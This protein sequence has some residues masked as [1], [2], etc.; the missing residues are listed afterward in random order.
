MRNWLARFLF[1]TSI[2]IASKE[3]LAMIVFDELVKLDA[4]VAAINARLDALPGAVDTSTFATVDAL[5]A[6]ANDVATIKSE[7]GT[8]PTDTGN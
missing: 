3:E 8:P 5:T 2:H 1:K 6:V 7:L 4:A